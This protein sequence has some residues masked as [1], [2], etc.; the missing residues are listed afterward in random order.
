MALNLLQWFT[1]SVPAPRPVTWEDV[2]GSDRLNLAGVDVTE[3][4]VLRF[5]PIWSGVSTLSRDIAKLPLVLYKNLPNGGKERFHGHKLYRI[6]HDEPNPEMTSF[7]FRETMQALCVL[8]GN[9]YAEIVRDGA[10]RPA[11]MYP[12]IPSRVVPFR[13]RENGRLRYRVTNPN[14]GQS[15]LNP[16]DVIHLSSLSLDGVLGLSL[17]SHAAESIGLGIATE[18]FGA[19][20]F[21]NGATFGGVVEIP[22]E[23]RQTA[24]D[25]ARSIIESIHQGVERAHKILVLAG[26][27]KFTQ[28]GTAPNEAQFLETRKF[29]INETA[30]WLNM[31]P[32]KLGDLENAHF[33]NIEEQ[34]LQYYV[35]CVSGWLEM[36]EQELSRKLISPLEYAQQSIEHVL[37]GVLR[38]DSAKRAAYYDTMLKNGSFS[39]NDVLRLENMN[40]IPNGDMH[41]VPLNMI[42]A[43]RYIEYIERVLLAP[44]TPPQ[45]GDGKVDEEPDESEDDPVEEEAQRK[46][47]ELV[48]AAKGLMQRHDARDVLLEQRA[49]SAEASRVE[50][51]HATAT[52]VE[53]AQIAAQR[54]QASDQRAAS[55]E[56]Q[57]VDAERQIREAQAAAVAAEAARQQGEDHAR[58]VEAKVR[59]AE[60]RVQAAEAQLRDADTRSEVLRQEAQTEA[61]TARR[62]LSDRERELGAARTALESATATVEARAVEAAALEAHL[63]TRKQAELDRL[64]RVM[65]AHRA[66]I[67]H[68]VQRLLKPEVE[69]ARRRQATPDT[70][71]KWADAFYVT[72][73]DVCADELYPAVLTSLAWQRSADD[74]HDVARQLAE[75][76]CAQSEHELRAVLD[77]TDNVDEFHVVLERVLTKW[78]QDRPNAMADQVLQQEIAYVSSYR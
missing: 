56:A 69:R 15:Y 19:S 10:G 64:T 75:A 24:K 44:K 42:P 55:I 23:A 31:P 25:G 76:H 33:T 13:E 21:G 45:I 9:A 16:M 49:L 40:P 29:Q 77:G 67:V 2:F 62:A 47:Q 38:G 1:R 37:E 7:K 71:R 43:E 6:L 17:A 26:G 20:F 60:V 61:E 12:I 46:L 35:G 73:R 22:G 51:E 36:W 34:E 50:A 28:R 5:S 57:L 3:E 70:L 54:V 48:E 30:R 68:A 74:P 4:S 65:S 66:L 63:E 39:I 11:G 58:I 53:Q 41:L 72:H 27:A 32:H 59:D 8:Y 18:R 52:A 14:G 78:E